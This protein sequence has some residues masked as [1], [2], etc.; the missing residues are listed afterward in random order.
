MA[1]SNKHIARVFYQI[2]TRLE[3]MGESPFRAGSYRKA[4]EALLRLPVEAADVISGDGDLPKMPGVGEVLASK[5]KT[6]ART[7][8]VD[9]A[10]RL[11]AQ[12][13]D[14]LVELLRVRGIT[15]LRIQQIRKALDISNIMEL[16]AAVE[17]GKIASV[18]GFGDVVAD[19][20][21]RSLDEYLSHRN[22]ILRPDALE[23]SHA[24]VA[25]LR[26][27]RACIK[28]EA[29]GSVRRG[30]DSVGNVDVV[31][32]FREVEPAL[33]ALGKWEETET[34]GQVLEG[35]QV[36]ARLHAGIELRVLFVP[37]DHFGYHVVVRTGS[38]GHVAA[39]AEAAKARNL[40]FDEE[41]LRGKDGQ[42]ATPDEESVYS[43]LGIPVVPPELR[44]ARGE[45]EAAVEGR[46][47]GLLRLEEMMGDLHC[48]TTHSDGAGSPADMAREGRSR[49]YKYIAV[50]DHTKNV[51]IANGMDA[52]RALVYLDGLERLAASNP[53]IAVLKALEV[54][55]LK[56]GTLDLPDDVIER[57][58]FIIGSIH[59]H[60]SLPQEEMTA[61]VVK[62]LEHPLVSIFAHPT[63][64]L[65]GSRSSIPL[66]VD[67]VIRTASRTGTVLEL[68]ANPERLDIND[69]NCRAAKAAGVKVAISSDAHAV[70]Q[71]DH[72]RFGV[73]QARR[74]WLEATDVV[75]TLPVGEL[76]SVL[77][78]K[79]AQ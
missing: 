57:F 11:K 71:L 60:F 3:V 4:A 54:D 53:G 21:R 68:N 9:L 36:T 17:A 46:L 6:I 61:R 64:R 41:F 1:Y 79:R 2:A 77:R 30:R 62:A 14:E 10:E 34:L 19:R 56:D 16:K 59:S 51:S 27:L 37:E 40:K 67:E 45:I 35:R 7:G 25:L 76:L 8:T 42:I 78:R 23:L 31:A 65:I 39:L 13:P 72:M 52:A 29:A 28:V 5:I 55:I 15:P 75:N 26:N 58:D 32:A 20:I 73:V 48:H 33:S 70:D 43:L 47:P 66:D 18:K 24:A 74:G 12:V 63:G 50:S 38:A 44:E 69:R 49:G 22:R